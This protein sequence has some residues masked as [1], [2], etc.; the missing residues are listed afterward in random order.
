MAIQIF[1]S[2]ISLNYFCNTHDG[3]IIPA[4]LLTPGKAPKLVCPLCMRKEN[5][6]REAIID[7]ERGQGI[8]GI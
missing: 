3:Y 2:G 5:H 6:I 1:Q 8:Q 7:E 4:K